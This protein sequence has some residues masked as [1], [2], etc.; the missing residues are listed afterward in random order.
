MQLEREDKL[1]AKLDAQR[2]ESERQRLETECNRYQEEG[3]QQESR[4][5]MVHSLATIATANKERCE[6]EQQFQRG[7]GTLL[8][9]F[10]TFEALY[11]HKIEQ[12]QVLNQQMR[13]HHSSM[14]TS[15]PE[16]RRQRDIFTQLFKLLQGKKTSLEVGIRQG[17]SA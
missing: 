15:A 4:Y 6:M 14:S 13:K 2:R 10:K 16:D 17:R 3:L 11:K 1:E 5:F 8:P 9:D 12:Q 7:E